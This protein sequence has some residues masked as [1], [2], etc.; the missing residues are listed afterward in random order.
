[1]N[2]DISNQEE[3][4]GRVISLIQKE[5]DFVIAAHVLPDGDAI[6]SILGLGL[7]LKKLNKKTFLTW[8]NH[9]YVSPHFSFLPAVDLLR[10]ASEC[11]VSPRNFIALD[12]GSVERLGRLKDRFLAAENTVNIDHH[13]DN[14][15]F[16]QINIVDEKSAACSEIIYTLARKLG[17]EVDQA[18]ATCLYTGIVTDTGRFQYANTTAKTFQIAVELLE[19]G[20]NP[21]QIFRNVYESQSFSDIRLFGL[22]IY[23]AELL[24]E[25]GIIY[26]TITQKDL[27]HT[28][29]RLEDTENLI[30]Y[31]RA[32]KGIE[33]A[34]VFKEL[35][36]GVRVSMRSIGKV[37]VGRIAEEYGGGGHPLAAGFNSHQNL[38][39][40]KNDLFQMISQYRLR[41]SGKSIKT[42]K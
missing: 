12:C 37:D 36:G 32:T 13:R 9:L 10:D 39:S 6:G 21:S 14:T 34:V 23:R 19:Y 18:I 2:S 26:T 17:V 42:D 41:P 29:T 40:T 24:P 33:V 11:P 3:N 1:M 25:L 28:R 16:A 31:L 7:I 22:A 35:N 38:E 30:D 20:V 15:S 4:W 8:A 5:T 27:D